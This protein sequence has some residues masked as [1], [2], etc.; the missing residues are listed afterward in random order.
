LK[1]I[2]SIEFSNKISNDDYL[3]LKGIPNI[4]LGFSLISDFEFN[5]LVD[6]KIKIKSFAAINS[7]NLTDK[8]LNYLTN[9]HYI[10]LVGCNGISNEGLKKLEKV[11]DL[12]IANTQITDQGLKNLVEI[13]KGIIK[14]ILNSCEITD[15]GL[16]YLSC[17][18]L[19]FLNVS[20][21]KNVT[22]EGLKNLKV[23]RLYALECKINKDQLD[24][25][26]KK[27]ID[28]N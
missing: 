20:K 23:K 28:V 18:K 27:N 25:L 11:T 10:C 15:I 21:C 22:H 2:E 7:K 24:E 9:S 1:N 13:N 5:Y 19:D 14:L 17:L 6:D 26:K 12:N 8:S 16:N 4:Y 3:L